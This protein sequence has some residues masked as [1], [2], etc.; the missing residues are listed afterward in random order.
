M[1]MEIFF[2]INFVTKENTGHHSAKTTIVNN[3]DNLQSSAMDITKSASRKCLKMLKKWPK[4]LVT[5][6]IIIYYVCIIMKES[7]GNA[8]LIGG[9]Y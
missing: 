9:S 2:D 4:I 5:Q 3:E 7:S 6:Y 8:N 1:F